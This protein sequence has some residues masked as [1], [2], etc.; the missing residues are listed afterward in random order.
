ML[1][2]RIVL[3]TRIVLTLKKRIALEW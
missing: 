2:L 1:N 3:I